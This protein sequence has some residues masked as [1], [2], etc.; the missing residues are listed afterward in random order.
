MV[1]AWTDN[2]SDPDSGMAPV[3]TRGDDEITRSLMAAV[4]PAVGGILLGAGALLVFFPLDPWAGIVCAMAGAVLFVAAWLNARGI[5]ITASI[6]VVSLC[7]IAPL[8]IPLWTDSMSVYL[9]FVGICG[10]LALVAVRRRLRFLPVAL[11]VVGAVLLVVGTDSGAPPPSSLALSVGGV[12]ALLITMVLGRRLLDELHALLAR[13]AADRDAAHEQEATLRAVNAGL[14][15]AV[16]RRERELRDAISAQRRLA[17]QLAAT[18]MHDPLTGL[19][20]RTYL[21]RQ[22]PQ[23]ASGAVAAAMLDIDHFKSVNELHSYET[24]DRV[25]QAVADAISDVLRSSDLL[26][27]YGGEEFL[28][29][30]PGADLAGATA[31]VERLRNAVAQR[32]W[33]DIA[34]GLSVTVSAGVACQAGESAD[35]HNP[36]ADGRRLLARADSA[37]RAA[38]NAGRNQ[39]CHAPED[40][41]PEDRS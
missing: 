38:K 21:D 39:V 33:D 26:I 28:V 34:P 18:A 24:G 12:L 32:E 6:A 4:I 16:A 13:A 27:R 25:I 37:L 31:G 3:D 36:A 2:P 10:A 29:L 11:A 1:P 5:V 23:L 7:F 30:M 9:Y 15:A 20:N 8:L 19:F 41:R 14:E 17:D 35:R 22:L 40:L